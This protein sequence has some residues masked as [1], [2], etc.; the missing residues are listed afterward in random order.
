MK[1]RPAGAE[2]YHADGRTD[3]TKLIIIF[4]NV[5]NAHKIDHKRLRRSPHL[6]RMDSNSVPKFVPHCQS[7]CCGNIIQNMAMTSEEN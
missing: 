7:Q 2:F 4:R 1:I 3:R 5:A 6:N